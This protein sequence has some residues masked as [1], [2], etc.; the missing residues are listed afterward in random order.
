MANVLVVDDEDNIR[1]LLGRFFASYNH[2]VSQA[3]NG[4]RAL[5]LIKGGKA[6]DVVLTD[7]RMDE[8]DGLELLKAIKT[9]SPDTPVV[10]MTAYGTIDNAVT[11]MKTGAFDYLTKPLKLPQVQLVL[12]RALEVSSLRSQNRALRDVISGTPLLVT[13]SRKFQAVIEDAHLAASSDSTILLTGESGTGKNVFARQIHDWSNRR[14]NPFVTINCANISEHLVDSELFGHVQ[15]AFTGAAKNK[16]GRVEA[17]DRGTAFLDEISEL[18]VSLQIKLLR[19]LQD[20]RFERVGGLQTIQVD[21]RIIA[22]SNRDLIKEIA[23][24]R[25]RADLYY[26]LNVI[27]LRVPP[28]RDRPEDVVALAE[29]FLTEAKTR[30]RR[31]RLRYSQDVIRIMMM[32]TWPGNIRELRN[33]VER[34]VVLSRGDTIAKEDLP[35][36]MFDP[37]LANSEHP[38]VDYSLDKMEEEHI[39]RVLL[40]AP[41]FEEAA[42]MLGITTATLWRK[43][44]LYHIE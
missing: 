40:Y 26:R 7:W 9:D 3:A 36:S 17:A 14:Q 25:F 16:R 2:E 15:G 22:A 12:D 5:E 20:G 11:A 35:D 10:L 30:N 41:T 39:K 6:F 4:A 23:E 43:R 34:A 8:V 27:S 33:V 37:E 29:R 28:L 42:Q 44:K 18:P 19:F 38:P 24:G 31:S 1:E 32:Y 21:V 13:K